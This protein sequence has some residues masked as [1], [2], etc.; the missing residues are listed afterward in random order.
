MRHNR[1]RLAWSVLITACGLFCA[2][3]VGIPLGLRWYLLNSMLEGAANVDTTNG[4]LVVALP[5][6]LG[7]VGVTESLDSIGEGA[8]IT[9]DRSSEGLIEFPDPGGEP[10][11]G[12]LQ[13]Y[14][15]SQIGLQLMQ[16]PRFGISPHTHRI[17]LELAAGRIRAR[18]PVD[19][20][21]PVSLTVKTPQGTAIFEQPGSFLVEVIQ[22]ETS[23]VVREGK[24][25]VTAQEKWVYLDEEENPR[26]VIAEG[27]GPLDGLPAER[28]LIADGDFASGLAPDWSER[29]QK[30]VAEE[31]DA[32]VT[33]TTASGG[34]A[35]KFS[36]TGAGL[37]WAQVGIRQEINRDVRELSSLRLHLAVQVNSQDLF[38]C[39]AL[40]TECP[41]MVKILYEDGGGGSYEW[42]KGF[43]TNSD[44][45]GR[46]PT[47]C[48]TCSPPTTE[49]HDH[50]ESGGL[51]TYDSPNLIEV[52][53]LQSGAAPAVIRAIEIYASGHSFDS[54]VSEV[55]LLAQE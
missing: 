30:Q 28:N 38:N 46:T 21:R 36:R 24:A 48:V 47:R 35:A 39:G 50:L 29:G 3:A 12:A 13:I 34:R 43:Y 31:P 37:N 25:A 11:L 5:D 40:G 27:Q 9:T 10:A 44:P 23:V 7:L 8:T 16:S 45:S 22:N 42:L 19:V 14:G 55:E 33:I 54:L 17:V 2:L 26:T 15:N 18:V 53:T 32:Q 49:E 51:R 6:Q 41:V 4:T 52:F 1:E 20:A